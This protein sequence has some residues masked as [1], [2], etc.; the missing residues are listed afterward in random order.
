M[1]RLEVIL[2]AIYGKEQERGVFGIQTVR[3]RPSQTQCGEGHNQPECLLIVLQVTIMLPLQVLIS[4]LFLLLPGKWEVV[5]DAWEDGGSHKYIPWGRSTGY[6]VSKDQDEAVAPKMFL[7]LHEFQ[8]VWLKY[9]T[10][11]T[12]R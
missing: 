2:K 10:H 6:I 4:G 3:M 5:G 1:L 9:K 8:N 11:K 7:N 12:V